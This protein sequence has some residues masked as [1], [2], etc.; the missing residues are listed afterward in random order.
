MAQLQV[1][2]PEGNVTQP[3]GLHYRERIETFEEDA[4]RVSSAIFRR[5][6]PSGGSHH[7]ATA[8]KHLSTVKTGNR[9][10]AAPSGFSSAAIRSHSPVSW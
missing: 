9:A 6:Q 7:C 1:V 4:Q 10:T 3:A 8:L 2:V 5:P